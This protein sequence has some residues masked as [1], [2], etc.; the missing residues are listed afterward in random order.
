MSISERKRAILDA[1]KTSRSPIR[2][3]TLMDSITSSRASLN[4]DLK[5]LAEAGLLQIQ[6]KGRSTRY[7]EG[8]DPNEPPK[9]RRQWSSA[10]TALLESLSTPLATR[11]LVRYDPGF[12][13]TYTPNLCSL[14]PPQL[15]LHL[16]HAGYRGQAGPVQAKPSEQPL[17]ELVWSSGC[18]DGISMRLDDAKLVLNGQPHADGLSR[19]ALVLLNHKDAID[20]INA[21]AP[22]QDIS[23]ESIVDVQALLMR[24]L[25]DAPLIGSIRTLP[26]YGC[27]YAPCN[28]PAVLR[29]LLKSIGD[30]AREVHNPIE[31]AFFTW[32]NLSYLQ[33]FNF[34]NDCTARL[35]ANIPLLHKNCAPLSFRGVAR[36]DYELALSGIYQKQDVKAAVELFELAYRQSAQKFYQ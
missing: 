5:S 1:V 15:A 33:A 20:Y 9:A 29:S 11:P 25:V 26:I 34:G 27:D 2:P 7:L 30:K 24:D 10:A 13:A 31:A 36:D 22:E 28:D 23:V 3:S 19:D 21:N 14:L 8:V 32:V 12:L 4:R 17:E 16:F 6:G 18:L 35:V